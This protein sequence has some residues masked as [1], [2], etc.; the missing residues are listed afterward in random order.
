MSNKLT[1]AL[2]FAMAA[3]MSLFSPLTVSHGQGSCCAECVMKKEEEIE[4]VDVE[5]N[6]DRESQENRN[7]KRILSV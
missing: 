7:K 6:E 4:I 2:S 5:E 1:L 3:V